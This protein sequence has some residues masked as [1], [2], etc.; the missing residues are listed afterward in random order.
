MRRNPNASI[1]HKRTGRENGF[2][3]RT[4]IRPDTLSLH[5]VKQGQTPLITG[6]LNS[7]PQFLF[8]MRPSVSWLPDGYS[9]FFQCNRLLCKLHAVLLWDS[10]VK[11]AQVRGPSWCPFFTYACALGIPHASYELVR[12]S[13][14]TYDISVLFLT[15][16]FHTGTVKTEC[17]VDVT[18]TAIQPHQ[19]FR[20]IP[21]FNTGHYNQHFVRLRSYIPAP[22]RSAQS[23]CGGMV[24]VE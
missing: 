8:D 2:A 16:H 1:K 11:D 7:S 24:R 19:M 20:P 15:P 14:I 21:W 18:L 5:R 9:K 12:I 4:K 23:H 6:E 17:Y 3:L 10:I 22:L 13:N